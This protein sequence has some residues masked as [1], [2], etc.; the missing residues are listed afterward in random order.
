MLEKVK[1]HKKLLIIIALLLVSGA[2]VWA[3]AKLSGQANALA[4][5][6]GIYS[7]EMEN[8]TIATIVKPARTKD[9]PS[10]PPPCDWKKEAQIKKALND[11]DA[12]YKAA[13]A[14]AKSEQ[15]AGQV[16]EATKGEVLKLAAE[17]QKLCDEYAAMWSA[18]NCATRAKTAQAAG[19]SRIKSAAVVAGGTI[20]TDLLA[21]LDAAQAKLRDA[22]AEYAK[23]AVADAEIAEEDKAAL[24]ATVVP[25][26]ETLV[27][28]MKDH[29]DAVQR[30]MMDIQAN[31]KGGGSSGGGGGGERI[32][33]MIQMVPEVRALY[34]A[35]RSMGGTSRNIYM[36]CRYLYAELLYLIFGTTPFYYGGIAGFPCFVDASME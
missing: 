20:N 19:E 28:K 17:Y 4:Q 23:T 35:T 13:A 15:S 10:A 31:P 26:A 30:L 21:A 27:A 3:A 5:D 32:S 18:C 8:L 33:P 14:K 16:S 7:A 2:L 9:S 24:K 36:A 25:A 11:N 12:K 22:R 34:E 6:T 1:K 29:V